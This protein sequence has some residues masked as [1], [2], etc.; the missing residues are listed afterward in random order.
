MQ[1]IKPDLMKIAPRFFCDND[2]I[3][4]LEKIRMMN[5]GN[6]IYWSDVKD[7]LAKLYGE[8]L[9]E[10]RFTGNSTGYHSEV[11]DV[12]MSLLKDFVGTEDMAADDIYKFLTNV[13]V[14]KE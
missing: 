14:K 12:L 9:Y 1:L 5:L 13:R 3:P 7:L 11:C 2:I 4:L 6:E 8:I 10:I